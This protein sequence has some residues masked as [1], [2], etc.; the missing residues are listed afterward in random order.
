[1]VVAST[2]LVFCEVF[3]LHTHY[4]MHIACAS[5]AY[6][7]FTA[8][9][10]MWNSSR[11]A[12]LT[13]TNQSKTNITMQ[14]YD[15]VSTSRKD[16][17][18]MITSYTN[19]KKQALGY[20]VNNLELDNKEIGVLEH[21]RNLKRLEHQW[22]SL[23]KEYS[24]W[25]S[26]T[27]PEEGRVAYGEKLSR[28]LD[29]YTHNLNHAINKLTKDVKALKNI[30][31]SLRSA[32]GRERS[33]NRERRI[34][35]DRITNNSSESY[36]AAKAAGKEEF[37]ILPTDSMLDDEDRKT[38]DNSANHGLGV[39]EKLSLPMQEYVDTCTNQGCGIEV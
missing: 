21:G 27:G 9:W 10:S 14:K 34:S 3:I 28:K 12:K 5:A 36:A 18:E 16:W 17:Q 15:Q 35:S 19:F 23:R 38:Q 22:C 25:V 20:G 8:L 37:N 2:L 4:G 32:D 31:N 26:N 24:L 1:M 7:C 29:E 6:L 33:K 11:Q 39:L 30:L 13:S